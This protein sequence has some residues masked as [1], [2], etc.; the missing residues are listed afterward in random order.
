MMKLN[1]RTL[2][3]ENAVRRD[4]YLAAAG[5]MVKRTV[6]FVSRVEVWSGSSRT[7]ALLQIVSVF[8]QMVH[9]DN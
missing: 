4:F 6:L 8:G 5:R 2:I 1:F 9:L 7:D 3:R